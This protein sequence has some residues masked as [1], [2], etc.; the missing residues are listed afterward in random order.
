MIEEAKVE[1]QVEASVFCLYLIVPD[2]NKLPNS[3]PT[4]QAHRGKKVID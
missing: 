4:M 3:L 1:V 2:S